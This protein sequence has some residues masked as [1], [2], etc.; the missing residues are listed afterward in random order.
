MKINEEYAGH[1]TVNFIVNELTGNIYDHTPFEQDYASYGYC[2]AQEYPTWKKVDICV[3]DDGLS[4][5]GK[6][7]KNNIQF[8][9]DCE[10]IEQVISGYSTIPNRDRGNGLGSCLK[11]MDANCGSALIVSRGAALEIDSKLRE[12]QYH[13][14]DNKDVF[15]GTLI[16]IKLR[17]NPVNFYDTLDTGVIFTTPYKYEGG[18]RC[19]IE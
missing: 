13:Q 5:P 7:E 16:T 8:D 18:K 6:L 10:A 19:K 4:I 2:Y 17:N 12:Y 9:D 14:L 11:L 15:K 3:Y 1:Q